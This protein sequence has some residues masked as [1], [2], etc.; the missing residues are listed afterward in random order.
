MIEVVEIGMLAIHLLGDIAFG[1]QFD[2]F[3]EILESACLIASQ[4][5]D[6]ASQL[7][8]FHEFGIVLDDLV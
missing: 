6:L 7:V 3:F 4:V 1:I 2:R 5:F 8:G